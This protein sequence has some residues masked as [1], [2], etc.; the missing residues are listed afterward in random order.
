MIWFFGNGQL[1]AEDLA[2]GGATEGELVEL[3][4]IEGQPPCYP[5]SLFFYLQE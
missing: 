2:L 5:L 3:Q 4:Q 1:V